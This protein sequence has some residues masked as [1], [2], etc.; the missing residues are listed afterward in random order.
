[1]AIRPSYLPQ[2]HRTTQANKVS[3][4]QN[5]KITALTL[6]LDKLE[7]TLFKEPWNGKARQD[8]RSTQARLNHLIAEAE[9]MKG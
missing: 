5:E 2:G 3:S 9:G 1:M 7:E 4:L 6:S 8:F